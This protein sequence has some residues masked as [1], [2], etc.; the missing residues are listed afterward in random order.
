MNGKTKEEIKMKKTTMLLCI[1]AGVLL[2]GSCA[3]TIEAPQP[4]KMNITLTAS[5]GAPGTK[6]TYTEKDGGGL[7]VTWDD[8]EWISVIRVN[9]DGTY[10]G[11]DDISGTKIDDKNYAFKGA[12]T[13]KT[14]AQSYLCVYPS[15]GMSPHMFQNNLEPDKT[16]VL[17]YNGTESIAQKE[18]GSTAHLKEADLMTGVPEFDEEGNATVSLE[19]QIGILKLDISFPNTEEFVGKTIG[20]IAFMPAAGGLVPTPNL[21]ITLKDGSAAPAESPFF[22]V[23]YM[24][25]IPFGGRLIAYAPFGPCTMSAGSYDIYIHTGEEDYKIATIEGSS[26]VVIERGCMSTLTID[27]SDPDAWSVSH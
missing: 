24:G 15:I 17:E 5:I 7:T 14:D 3:K 13:T 16:E 11:H 12:V 23:S 9:E 26:D 2:A 20:L 18:S 8:E 6:T 19:R 21:T 10:A 27:K 4:E 1:A 25:P 22:L